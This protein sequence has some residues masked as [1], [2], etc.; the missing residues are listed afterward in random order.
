MGLGKIAV[1]GVL[2]GERGKI[3][4][5]FLDY[6]NHVMCMYMNFLSQSVFFKFL[7][8]KH[9]L[10]VVHSSSLTAVSRVGS[11]KKNGYVLSEKG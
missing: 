2:N 3:L 1:G 8:I 11:E 5:A 4:C 6:V 10:F 9:E 7:F